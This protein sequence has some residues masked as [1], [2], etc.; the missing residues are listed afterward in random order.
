MS[1]CCAGK[2]L[3][4]E[5]F[6]LDTAGGTGQDR[7]GTLARCYASGLETTA[8]TSDLCVL[9]AGAGAV[10]TAT[11]SRPTGPR[12]RPDWTGWCSVGTWTE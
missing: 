6:A 1:L 9:S 2:L 11:R 12:C 3:K 10:K 8:V 4:A 7:D 5:P